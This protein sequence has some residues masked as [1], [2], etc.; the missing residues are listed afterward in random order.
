MR[1]A[2]LVAVLGALLTPAHADAYDRQLTLDA[3]LGWGIAP[4][5]E[6]PNNGPSFALGTTFGFDDTWGMGVYAAWAVHPPFGADAEAEPVDPVQVG[7][8]G[9][10]GLYYI[11]IVQVVPFFGVG[12]DVMPVYDGRAR[13]WGAEFAAHLRLSLDYLVSR[14]VVIGLDVR[15][16]LLFTNLTRDPVYLQVLGRFSY[17]LDL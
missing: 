2:L 9:V 3:A 7:I 8:L 14:D 5:L 4:G 12:V 6:A 1:P 11:D 10:E 17:V 16:Y 13:E 15:P